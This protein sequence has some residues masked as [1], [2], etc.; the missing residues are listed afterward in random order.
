METDQKTVEVIASQYQEN[1]GEGHLDRIEE[2]YLAVVR[3]VLDAAAMVGY[4]L[5]RVT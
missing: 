1:N 5:T 2:S 3:E 4:T